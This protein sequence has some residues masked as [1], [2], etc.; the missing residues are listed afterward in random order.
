MMPMTSAGAAES[1][2]HDADGLDHPEGGTRPRYLGDVL[3][4]AELLLQHVASIGVDVDDD[5][6]KSVLRGR[7]LPPDRWTD[8][9]A[10][11]LLIAYTKLTA[12]LCPVTAE[13]LKSCAQPT[14]HQLGR[15]T[16]WVAA[17]IVPFSLAS[18]ISSAIS[19]PIRKDIVTAND[20]AVKLTAQLGTSRAPATVRTDAIDNPGI[21]VELQQFAATIRG[22]DTRARQ[23]NW[24]VLHMERDP[25][26]SIRHNPEKFH[27][28]FELPPELPNVVT[29][30]EEK[31]AVLQNVRYF[32]QSVLDDVSLV[33]GA[34]ATCILPVLY[35]ILGTCA[36]LLRRFEQE[37]RAKTFVPSKATSARFLIAAICGA[38]VGL[39]NF[40]ITQ[41]ASISPLAIAFL[42]GYATDVFF[43]FLEVLTK[44]TSG[45]SA[46]AALQGNPG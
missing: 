40:T 41:G 7:A 1:S 15:V 5:V 34:I 44:N 10:D 4:D 8:Q 17:F 39:F 46:K 2:D 14:V 31:L 33:Y 3:E 23:L 32:A 26:A 11:D 25:Y 9:T 24:F 12:R 29:V 20:L 37:T 42:A 19:D 43:S 18:F 35:A 36:Y 27:E 13:S 38:V 16:F 30:K 28:T 6:R 22:I 21:V 45:G